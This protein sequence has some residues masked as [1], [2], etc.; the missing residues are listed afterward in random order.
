MLNKR[1]VDSNYDVTPSAGHFYNAALVKSYLKPGMRILDIGCWTGQLYKAIN[2][3]NVRYYGVDISKEAIALAKKNFT[4][5]RWSVGSAVNLP[6]LQGF[7][8]II[9][10][11]DVLEHIPVG[12]EE[13][14]LSCIRHLLKQ[15]GVFIMST[16]ASNIISIVTDPAYFLMGHRHYS[17]DNLSKLMEKEGLKIIDIWVMGGLWYIAYYLIQ[18]FYKHILRNVTGTSHVLNFFKSKASKDLDSEHSYLEFYLV[19][20]LI[21]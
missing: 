14:S 18:M 7:F 5:G 16:P 17:K 1:K 15:N 11:F 4:N 8:D 21:K 3:K 9:V 6:F 10:M 13:K 19:A 12:T 20:R 2:A